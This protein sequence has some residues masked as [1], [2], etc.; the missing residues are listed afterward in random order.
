MLISV[1]AV[2]A[3]FGAAPA[4][5]AAAPAFG[6]DV[7]SIPIL[8]GVRVTWAAIVVIPAVAVCFFF[9]CQALFKLLLFTLAFQAV[10][11]ITVE[12]ITF[13]LQASYIVLAALV[14]R[15]IFAGAL[16]AVT[17]ALPFAAAMLVVVGGP[18][19]F[20]YDSYPAEPIGDPQIRAGQAVYWSCAVVFFLAAYAYARTSQ[21]CVGGD[22]RFFVFGALT[23]AGIGFYQVL[24]DVLGWYYPYEF[25]NNNPS[26]IERAGEEVEGIE[27]LVGPLPEASMFALLA[28]V[29]LP[30]AIGLTSVGHTVVLV[31]ALVLSL[32]TTAIIALGMHAVWLAKRAVGSSA[33]RPIAFAS[34]F[35]AVILL[36]IPA[37]RD[38]AAT[39][40]VDKL[41]SHSGTVRLTAMR[42]GLDAWLDAPLLGWGVGAGQTNDGLSNALLAV[43]IVGLALLA[44][45]IVKA[46]LIHSGARPTANYLK[47]ALVVGAC[48]HLAAVAYWTFPYVWLLS[49]TLWAF[50]AGPWR[51]GSTA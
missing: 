2:S 13:G 49:G 34:V 17:P 1:F 20:R 11:V 41:S 47:I 5:A 3:A 15:L 31:A 44:Y 14:L 30:L 42:E 51:R 26:F 40:T 35:A 21:K 25:L 39:L 37:V 12:E 48:L 45:M 9:G 7:G 27:R 19:L 23:A 10:A 50:G 28:G 18:L 33:V 24:A 29:A 16:R 46:V 4:T 38:A 22:W 8:E 36:A 6:P 32:S 43:G